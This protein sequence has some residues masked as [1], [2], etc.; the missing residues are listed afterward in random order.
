MLERLRVVRSGERAGVAAKARQHRARAALTAKI[1]KHGSEKWRS[2]ASGASA[3]EVPSR[4]E[5]MSI[6]RRA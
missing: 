2:R 3:Q 4:A 1:E 5:P 6:R